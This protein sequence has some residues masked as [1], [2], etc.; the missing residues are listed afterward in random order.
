[1]MTMRWLLAA[2]AAFGCTGVVSS[3]LGQNPVSA[4]TSAQGQVEL[5]GAGATFPAPLYQKWIAVYT[6]AN[7]N[8]SIKYQGVGSGE[9]SQLFLEQK[10]DFGASDAALNDEQ[11]AQA[12]AGVTLVPT[13]AGIVVLAYNL[14]DVKGTLK[15]SRDVYADIF[16]GKIRQWNDPRIQALNPELKLPKQTITLVARKDSSGTTYALTNHLSTISETWHT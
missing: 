12:K 15:L 3:A 16:A 7:P 11:I 2:V 9:G 8:V 5:R 4:G 14:P 6:Q 1:M 10:V 13:T